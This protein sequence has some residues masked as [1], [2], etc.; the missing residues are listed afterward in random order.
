MCFEWLISSRKKP[1]RDFHKLFECSCDLCGKNFDKL[2]NLVVHTGVHST[3]D[4][5]ARLLGGYG[6]VRCNKCRKSFHAYKM[7]APYWPA[8]TAILH[9][10]PELHPKYDRHGCQY[11]RG[12]FR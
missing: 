1:H 3:E 6:T 12:R 4:I 9:F 10:R 7:D 11:Y 2:E 5:N 8:P